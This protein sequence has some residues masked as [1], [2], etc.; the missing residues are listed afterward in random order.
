AA[1]P[2]AV[3]QL[4]AGIF[5]TNSP[6]LIPPGI[7]LKGV[8]Q[9]TQAGDGT[10]SD[11]ATTIIPVA[12]QWSNTYQ[13]SS[14]PVVSGN[15]GYGQGGV[16]YLVNMTSPIGTVNTTVQ[17]QGIVNIWI[18]MA[19]GPANVDA[20][21]SWG[22]INATTLSGIGINQPQGNGIGAYENSNFSTSTQPDGW[23]L[24]NIIIEKGQQY[25]F[26]GYFQDTSFFNCHAQQCGQ[27]NGVTADG[28][29]IGWSHNNLVQCRSDLNSGNGYTLEVQGGQSHA[30]GQYW[31][32]TTFAGCTTQRN[33]LS[34]LNIINTGND[35]ETQQSPVVCTGCSFEGDGTA[36]VVS[37]SYPA[38]YVSGRQVVVLNGCDIH[39]Y[40]LD[41]ANGCPQYALQTSSQGTGPGYPGVVIARGGFW[42]ATSELIN[43]ANGK[44]YLM[45]IDVAG[46]GRGAY[47]NQAS[48]PPSDYRN[49]QVSTV[50]GSYQALPNNEI[51]LCSAS[52]GTATVNLPGL[53]GTTATV[54]SNTSN[55]DAPPTGKRFIVI[56]TDSSSNAITVAPYITA[57]TTSSMGGTSVS[58]F[59]GTFTVGS[60]TGFASSNGTFQTTTT[61]GYAVLSYATATGTTFTGCAVVS[62]SGSFTNGSVTQG[63]NSL[64]NGTASI[65]LAAQYS[66]MVCYSDGSNW[67]VASN[68]FNTSASNLQPD[69]TATAGST[70][71][72][73]DAGHI[74]PENAWQSLS[75]APTGVVA[76]TFPRIMAGGT[77]PTLNSGYLYCVGISIPAG[78]T[79]TGAAFCVKSTA[80][81]PGDVTAGWYVLMDGNLVVKAVT[82]NQT[83]GNPWSSTNTLYQFNFNSS[84]TF[85]NSGIHYIGFMC[86]I[87][88]GSMP[89]L[90]VV[91]SGVP[92]GIISASPILCGY[93]ATGQSLPP[94]LNTNFGPTSNMTVVSGFTAYAYVT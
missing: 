90:A 18:D 81:T 22:K 1:S 65:T 20:I 34:A 45:S 76:E 53:S 52:G 84:Y 49:R 73:A 88:A 11:W 67:W 75:V 93:C 30:S 43:T 2:G 37:G 4:G 6:I 61:T 17:R 64:I 69:G 63:D 85:S 72:I 71:L 10:N 35:G 94:S 7:F 33:K 31:A 40:S 46:Y 77:G 38:V 48:T 42:N 82:A 36:S 14:L 26:Y 55:Y 58:G 74:H 39:C 70:G 21:F 79:A 51:I 87:S 3:V 47:L 25:G 15:P 54:G 23:T 56:K 66:Q 60:T 44:P 27:G 91:N 19:N 41:N 62:G 92:G 80:T 59:T 24:Q 32:A 68:P 12:S 5:Y 28:F 83:T 57:T 29:W 8:A 13:G 89:V 78:V 16:I 50:S 86:A 9:A